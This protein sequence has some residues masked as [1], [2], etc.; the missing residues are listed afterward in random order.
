M[1]TTHRVK[2]MHQRATEIT[3]TEEALARVATT[4]GMA[5]MEAKTAEE[6]AEETTQSLQR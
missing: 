1:E 4:V 5:M 6:A 2:A 3:V